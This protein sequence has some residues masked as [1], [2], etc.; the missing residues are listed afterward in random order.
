MADTEQIFLNRQKIK[1]CYRYFSVSGYD[2]VKLVI[3]GRWDL[4]DFQ[5]AFVWRPSQV[6]DLADSLWRGY[7]IGYLLMWESARSA[8]DGS[9]LIADGQQRLTSLSLLFGEQPSW[10]RRREVDRRNLGRR[11]DLRFDVEATAPPWFHCSF[12]GKLEDSNGRLVRVPE[13]LAHDPA[14]EAGRA[15]LRTIAIRIKQRGRCRA[16]A[17]DQ[18]YETL[19]RVCIIRQ[20]PL[21]ATLLDCELRDVLEIFERLNS[22]GTRF[23]RLLLNLAM[24]SLVAASRTAPLRPGTAASYGGPR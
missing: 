10:W 2:A 12:D 14:T 20:L 23:R 7:P 3:S 4:P 6:S 21:C 22:R 13:I 15:A 24:R 19:H 9:F 16:L 11:F 1:S 5:R 17:E 18:V 8:A